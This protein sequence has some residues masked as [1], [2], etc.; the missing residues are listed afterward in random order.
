[1]CEV[2]ERRYIQVTP[3]EESNI[4]HKECDIAQKE[5]EIPQKETDI[6]QKERAIAQ[7]VVERI[8]NLYAI[9]LEFSYEARRY[10]SLGKLCKR[11]ISEIQPRSRRSIVH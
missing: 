2:Y 3:E 4:A 6:A 10:L 11:C 5:R 9:I 1:M 8:P 7:K